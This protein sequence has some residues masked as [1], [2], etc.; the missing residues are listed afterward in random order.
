VSAESRAALEAVRQ[1]FHNIAGDVVEQPLHE[2]PDMLITPRSRLQGYADGAL[3]LHLHYWLVGAI[4]PTRRHLCLTVTQQAWSQGDIY[5]RTVRRPEVELAATQITGDDVETVVLVGVVEVAD[6][7]ERIGLR[8]VGGQ[9]IR[10][11]AADQ[12]QCFGRHSTIDV[13]HARVPVVVRRR[14]EDWKLGAARPGQ[15]VL[16][17][18]SLDQST[19]E[20]IERP[21][22]VVYEVADE[23]T[24]PLWRRTLQYPLGDDVEVA[25]VLVLTYLDF[26]TV[27]FAV[28]VI[29]QIGFEIEQVFVCPRQLEDD[30][31]TCG[32]S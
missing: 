8:I 21:A 2:R 20:M 14:S 26:K 19:R 1:R 7:G 13:N 17:G 28:E 4:D 24:D 31:V 9:D 16:S 3:S 15:T 11:Q 18:V 6:D 12:C 30:T 29:V 25:P 5:D 32:G 23:S 22:Q 10:L 27:R